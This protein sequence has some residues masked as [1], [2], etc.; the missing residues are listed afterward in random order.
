MP[1]CSY[2]GQSYRLRCHVT[3]HERRSCRLRPG[4]PGARQ[5]GRVAGLDTVTAT[6]IVRI[7]AARAADPA[8]TALLERRLHEVRH[9]RALVV[10]GRV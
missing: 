9:E 4:E 1:S 8:A 2:C 7:R 6:L 5:A 3:Y 10:R